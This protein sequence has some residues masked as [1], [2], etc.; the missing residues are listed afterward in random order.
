MGY[1]QHKEGIYVQES[2]DVNGGLTHFGE[3]LLQL[4]S[5]CGLILCNSL[6]CFPLS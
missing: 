6:K 3:E 4:A 2:Q 1:A 5:R